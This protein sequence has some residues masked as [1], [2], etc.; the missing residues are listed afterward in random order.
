MTKTLLTISVLVLLGATRLSAQTVIN[1]WYVIPPTSGCNGVWAVDASQFGSCGTGPFQY[2]MNPMGCVQ[3]TSNTAA[4]TVYWNLC[5]FP[6]DL[7]IVDMSGNVCICG[8]GTTTDAPEHSADRI[9]TTYPNPATAAGGWNVLLHQ[10]G[11]NVTVSIYNSLGQLVISE[12]QERAGQIVQVD[13]SSL[14]AGMY[15]TQ[16]SINGAAAYTQQLAVT[17]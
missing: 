14:T 13:I 9:V 16:I 15:T 17:Q 10:P 4:D 3:M 7:T 5:A 6:C 8:T 2:N 12:Q 1:T 11:E